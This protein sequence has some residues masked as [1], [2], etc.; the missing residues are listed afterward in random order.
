M[1]SRQGTAEAW[2]TSSKQNSS[3]KLTTPR[4]KISLTGPKRL[5]VVDFFSGSTYITLV[6][7]GMCVGSAMVAI[8]AVQG[9]APVWAG[10]AAGMAFATGKLLFR[11]PLV[12]H[13]P[14][15]MVCSYVILC[16]FICSFRKG[17]HRIS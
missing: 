15:H 7:G 9:V 2:Q 13:S 10:I 6:A 8:G 16:R 14:N 5:D 11:A 1:Y 4:S 3:G 17:D 12:S